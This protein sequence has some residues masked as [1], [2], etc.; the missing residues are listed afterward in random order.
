MSKWIS[1]LEFQMSSIQEVAWFTKFI[2]YS[3]TL[4]F[5]H[6]P[7]IYKRNETTVV[8]THLVWKEIMINRKT[9]PKIHG[10][11]PVFVEIGSL[12]MYNVRWNWKLSHSTHSQELETKQSRQKHQGSWMRELWWIRTKIIIIWFTQWRER[13]WEPNIVLFVD[14]LRARSPWS[15]WSC[16]FNHKL[17]VVSVKLY[18]THHWQL[19]LGG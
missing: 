13:V 1:M 7:W 10:N 11:W 3:P 15:V 4:Y 12:Q 17:Y 6:L 5:Y 2:I 18:K 19:K 9:W 8:A 14:V 16:N